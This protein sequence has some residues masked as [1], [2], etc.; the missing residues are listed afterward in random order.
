MKISPIEALVLDALN[1]AE[2]RKE[3]QERREANCG[4]NHVMV[5]S[6]VYRCYRCRIC[7]HLSESESG[8]TTHPY[9]DRD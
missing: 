4:G 1:Q 9:L 3:E 2:K 8:H 5:W 6:A 7:N